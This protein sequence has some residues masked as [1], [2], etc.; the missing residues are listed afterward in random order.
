[1]AG[2]LKTAVGAVAELAEMLYWDAKGQLT[3]GGEAAQMKILLQAVLDMPPS[4][5]TPILIVVEPDRLNITFVTDA[6]VALFTRGPSNPAIV[7][8]ANDVYVVGKQTDDSGDTRITAMDTVFERPLCALVP[9]NS[10]NEARLSD[11]VYI[12]N[13][14]KTGAAVSGF[15]RAQ[16]CLQMFL[17]DDRKLYLKNKSGQIIEWNVSKCQAVACKGV[18]KNKKES[19]T[20]PTSIPWTEVEDLVRDDVGEEDEPMTAGDADAADAGAADGF[21][22]D[23]EH[24]VFEL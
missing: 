19:E 16:I 24:I 23:F 10:F 15:Y 20:E 8:D 7:S 5:S 14:T 12:S 9:L 22:H 21:E 3:T 18:A 6:G 4:D 1:M 17:A 11:L 13:K 2:P